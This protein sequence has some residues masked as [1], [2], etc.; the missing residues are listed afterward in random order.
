[1]QLRTMLVAATFA[2]AVEASVPSELLAQ[3]TPEPG[4]QPAPSAGVGK[5][6]HKPLERTPRGAPILIRAQVKDPARLFAPLVFARTAG[7][8]RYGAYTMADRGNR[9]FFVRLPPA[10]L[11]EGSFEYFIEAR[12]DEGEPTRF[13]S[14]TQPFLC[15]AFDPPA[16]PV[17]ATF[18]TEEPGATL[19]VDDNEAGK[20]PVTVALGPGPHVIQVIA[21]DGRS[22]EQQIDVKP[23][24]KLDVVVPLPSRAGGP[25]SLGVTSDPAGARV[26]LDGAVVGVTPYST[27]LSPG[28]HGVAVELAG[29]LRQERQISARQGRDVQLAF[30]LP[31]MPKEPALT[32]ESEPAGASVVIDG[33][34]R[35]RTPFLAPVSAGTHELV[36]RLAGRREVGTELTMPKDK[37]LSLRMELGQPS[38]APRLTVASVPDRAA[39]LVDGKEV[40]LTPWSGELKPGEHTVQ[41]R[42][43]GYQAAERAVTL[44]A[45]RDT[46]LS[47]APERIAGPGRLRVE[48]EPPDAE[49]AIDGVAA[50]A[51]PYSGELPAGDHNVEISS[52]GYR[53]LAQQISLASGQQISLRL[54]LS[55]AGGDNAPPIVGVNSAPEGAMLYL[56]GKLIGPTPKKAQTTAGQHE[57]RLVLDGYKTWSAPTRLPDK[58]GYELRVAVALKPVREAEAHDA[59]AAVELARAEYKRAEACYAAGDYGCATA[60]YR[61]A[62]E[63]SHRP[64]LLFNLAQAHRRGG[65]LKEALQSY[66]SFL[67]EK[68]DPNPKV[69]A[70]AEQY[71]AFCQLVLQPA[72]IAPPGGQLAQKAAGK[73]PPA[74]AVQP[75]PGAAAQPLPGSETP[76]LPGFEAPPLPPLPPIAQAAPERSVALPLPTLPDEDTQPPVLTHQALR[77]APAGSALRLVARI[78]DERSAVGEAQACWRN[79]FHIEYECIPLAPAANDE[80]VAVIPGVAVADGFAYYLEASDSLGNGPA[81]SG[82]PELP[83][84]IAVEEPETPFRQ[85]IAEAVKPVAQ[86]GAVQARFG[87]PGSQQFGLQRPVGTL[88]EATP[89]Q[90]AWNVRALLGAERST[91]SYTQGV[92]RGYAALE[93]SRDLPRGFVALARA[94]W[95]SA[96]QPYVLPSAA[97]PQGRS[98][99]DEQ[100]YDVIGAGGYELGSA[101]ESDGRF[102]LQPMLGLHYLAL[103]SDVSPVDYLGAD[104]MLRG[105]FRA[106]RFL[107]ARAELAYT[108]PLSVSQAQSALGRPLRELALR[109]GA[110]LPFGSR[111]ALEV[112][113]QA[114]FLAFTYVTRAAHGVALGFDTSF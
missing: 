114:D 91:E 103:R 83:H 44:Q 41:V 24:R 26:Y 94:E 13:G 22:T 42:R 56:D 75:L 64:E 23:G 34:E 19:K 76:P 104:L 85:A 31:A 7:S 82:T 58:P 51:A 79:L 66:Q 102:S 54:T 84:S 111:Y 59:P 6:E 71:V 108:F 72:A 38:G 63:Y 32:V 48:T 3:V 62:Y 10:I 37:D 8:Q 43:A 39:V 53:S 81:R 61:A 36:L 2:A 28:G 90:R 112:S 4:V 12:H 15:V 68:R 17:K 89:G 98:S 1:M 57:L 33:K 97:D 99:F 101:L 113:Y 16:R 87:E 95:R 88:I 49:I 47:F 67:R 77:R 11:E 20:T 50:G 86:G 5:I 80:Y 110:A 78:V 40:G 69:K 60:G 30:V 100:R 27:E 25:A 73:E 74:G 9:G 105:S 55:A 14:P 65:N 29:R 52:V 106:F 35:G 92:S 109:A 96:S 21:A 46:H 45:N 107:E 93:A 70:Q 18:R